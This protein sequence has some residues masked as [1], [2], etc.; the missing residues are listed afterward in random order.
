MS[1]F[2]EEEL[3]P[4]VS[5]TMPLNEWPIGDLMFMEHLLECHIRKYKSKIASRQ[6]VTVKQAIKDVKFEQ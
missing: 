2:T 4:A 1:H 3:T 6:L 5:E